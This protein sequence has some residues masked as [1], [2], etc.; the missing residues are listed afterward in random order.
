[1]SVVSADAGAMTTEAALRYS[2]SGR[3]VR[4]DE[5]EAEAAPDQR[6]PVLMYHRVAT[7][8]SER[9]QRWRIHPDQFERQLAFLRDAGYYSVGFDHWRAAANLRRPLPGKPI[10]LTFD[11]GYA[12]FPEHVPDLLRRYG[13]GAT[14]FVVSEL[15]GES[16]V[17]DAALGE[18]LPLMDWATIER[19]ADEGID[20]GSHSARH[21]P[22]VAL[23][24]EQLAADLACSRRLLEE[25]LG[26]PV[27]SLSYPFG[28]HDAMVKAMAAG[29][30]Y[31]YGVTTDGWLASWSDQ[32]LTL[33]RLEA[34]GTDSLDDF[35]AMLGT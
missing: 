18:S 17:W 19:L 13:F 26:R 30:G 28:L 6:L 7:G 8:G 14:V 31:E 5:A 3:P 9:T 16:N 25:R 22:L 23:E 15:V 11:D 29:C 35:A 2:A 20:F 1:V 34:H 33:P 10:V 24:P 12:D 21:R 32:L 27:T 4:V